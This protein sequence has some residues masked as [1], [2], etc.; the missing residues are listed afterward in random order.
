MGKRGA[1]QKTKVAEQW[2]IWVTMTDVELYMMQT[3]G[4]LIGKGLGAAATLSGQ[5]VT[6]SRAVDTK[7]WSETKQGAR[8][9]NVGEGAPGWGRKFPIEE[10][11]CTERRWCG[12]DTG[13][14]IDL[15]EHKYK[16]HEN[17]CLQIGNN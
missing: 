17:Y 13:F 2:A 6:W 5:T 16:Y 4:F 15:G 9:S 12:Q 14:L 11:H 8:W 1:K 3:M 10:W 7:V